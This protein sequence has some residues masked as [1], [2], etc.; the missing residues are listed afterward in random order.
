MSEIPKIKLN[1]NKK[2]ITTGEILSIACEAAGISWEI[3]HGTIILRPI[4]K[5]KHRELNLFQTSFI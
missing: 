2:N 4:N 3:G 1:I 5:E